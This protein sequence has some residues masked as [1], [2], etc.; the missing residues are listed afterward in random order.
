ME[1]CKTLYIQLLE[2]ISEA[3]DRIPNCIKDKFPGY[4]KETYAKMRCLKLKLKTV[5]DNKQINS[6][7]KE[8][9][10]F[11]GNDI[12]GTSERSPSIISNFRDNTSKDSFI[13]IQK[14]KETKMNNTNN[15]LETSTPDNVN[16]TKSGP[17]KTIY[18]DLTAKKSLSFDVFSPINDLSKKVTDDNKSDMDSLNTSESSIKKGKFVFKKPSRMTLDDSDSS[19][20]VRDVPSNTV[21]RLKS[22]SEKLKP[23]LPKETVK[24][25]PVTNSS[26]EFQPP[27]LSKSSFE[28]SI[29]PSSAVSPSV[30]MQEEEEIDDYEVPVDLDDDS[31]AIQISSQ[32]SLINISDSLPST[33]NVEIVNNKEIVVDDDG[34]PEYRLE[35]FED[36]ADL[37]DLKESEEMDLMD[38]STIVDSAPKYQGMGDFHAGTKNDGITGITYIH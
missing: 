1:K 12:N 20:P 21:D 30:N 22:A 10:E 23:I 24:F 14:S 4:D 16:F 38:Q 18:S 5:I 15:D 3:F 37:L 19:T 2:K 34:W 36:D 32:T 31:D 35:D 9:I 11:H 27:H 6:V 7:N 33:S 29:K 13:N 8:S 28:D 25:P 26:V 17:N